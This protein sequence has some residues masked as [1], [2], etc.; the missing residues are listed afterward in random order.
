MKIATP[1]NNNP[2]LIGLC[3]A[4]A[5]LV[6]GLIV[7][8]AMAAV[9][10][11]YYFYSP[12]R[13]WFAGLE[14]LKQRWGYGYSLVSGVLAGAV[15]PEILALL[16]FQK[17][18]ITRENW[19]RLVFLACYWGGQSMVVDAFYRFQ[20]VLF[21]TQVD[22]VTVAK[23][24]VIDQLI[25]TPFYANMTAMFCFEWKNRGYRFAGL[26]GRVASREFFRSTMFPSLVANWVV[27]IPVVAMIYSLPSLLQLPLQNL[28]LTF[29]SLLL[30]WIT[31]RKA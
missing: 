1:Q 3:A 21:G 15:L 25:Y 18:R 8:A 22:V 26:W 4:R 20:G 28:A 30:T 16:V 5:N 24:M 29:W 14:L 12:A 7:Q 11:A 9:V 31:R 6:P 19:E 10:C 23:K 27:W 13:E 17:G 2:L